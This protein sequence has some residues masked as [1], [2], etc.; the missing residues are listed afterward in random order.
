MT[1]T[2]QNK[3]HAPTGLPEDPNLPKYPPKCKEE[4]FPVTV[5]SIVQGTGNKQLRS[6]QIGKQNCSP[7]FINMYLF[8]IAGHSC[9]NKQFDQHHYLE[10]N[11]PR[12]S[13]FSGR[14]TRSLLVSTS[15]GAGTNYPLGNKLQGIQNRS[16]SRHWRLKRSPSQARNRMTPEPRCIRHF[17]LQRN[18]TNLERRSIQVEV[19]SFDRGTYCSLAMNK[20]RFVDRTH[21]RERVI[22][23]LSLKAINR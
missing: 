18:R 1:W 20:K 16:L 15:S 9:Q 17:S 6:K 23:K 11:A 2:T 3:L 10:E 7:R 21:Q 14:I 4:R 22:A 8:C 19:L 5:E 13:R 12:C